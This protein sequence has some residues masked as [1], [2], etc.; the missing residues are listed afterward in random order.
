MELASRA[1]CRHPEDD[2]VRDMF[3]AHM[4]IEKI[5]GEILAETR[6]PED[7][8]NYGIRREKRIKY[9]RITI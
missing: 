6:N 2:W 7:A 3:T 1:D 9:N 5:A 8:H 4:H